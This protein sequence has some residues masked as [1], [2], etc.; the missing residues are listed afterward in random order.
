MY[1]VL[2]TSMLAVLFM[3]QTSH[4]AE[5]VLKKDFVNITPTY[6]QGHIGSQDWIKGFRFEG[7]IIYDS[8]NIGNVNGEITLL[9]PPLDMTQKYYDAFGIFN[10]V[11]TNVGSF[12]VFAQVKSLSA[13]D[14]ASTGL[15]MVSWH[16][17]IVNGTGQLQGL[18]GLSAGTVEYNL[19]SRQGSGTE[20]LNIML[21]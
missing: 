18:Q 17:S 14:I 9:N 8:S 11:I 6:M 16:G 20:I 4:A 19:F 21:D 12:Q 2:V 7:T 10:N 1:K 3:F 15:G 13:I 5:V